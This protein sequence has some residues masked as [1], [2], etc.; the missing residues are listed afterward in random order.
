M[1]QSQGGK[2]VG[3]VSKNLDVLVA[4][5]KAGS[6]LEKAS[7]LSIEIWDEEKL[8]KELVAKTETVTGS[9]GAQPTLFD[10]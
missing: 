10:Y 2:T 1:I 8:M 6:K 9:M 3:S 7:N 5:E 4:G